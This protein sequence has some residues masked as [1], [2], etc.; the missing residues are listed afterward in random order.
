[1]K[2]A[3]PAILTRDKDIVLVEVPDLGILT[4]G[5]SV[6]A[7]IYM[8]R[9]AIGLA[10]VTLQDKKQEVPKPSALEDI[11]IASGTFADVGGGILTLVDIDFDAYRRKLDRKMVRRNVTLPEWLNEAADEANLNVSGV[12][13]EALKD[14][15][16]FAKEA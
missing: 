9:N 14:K 7:A 13:Q 6:A 3:Y 12:L 10:G 5:K 8:A 2:A 4:E 11:D 1:M 16:G 15:L